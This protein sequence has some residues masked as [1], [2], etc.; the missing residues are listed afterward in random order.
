[1]F[2][3]GVCVQ[4][5]VLNTTVESNVIHQARSAR[6]MLPGKMHT[7]VVTINARIAEVIGGFHESALITGALTLFRMSMHIIIVILIMRCCFFVANRERRC[8]YC[9]RKRWIPKE[10][11]CP[12]WSAYSQTCLRIQ[13][14][15]CCNWRTINKYTK[16]IWYL[17]NTT[18]QEYPYMNNNS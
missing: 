10:N 9:R 15:T 12:C 3:V 8:Y 11:R 4:I 2:L 7:S 13:A 14:Y 6:S 16:G 17:H 1:M 18:G 5:A